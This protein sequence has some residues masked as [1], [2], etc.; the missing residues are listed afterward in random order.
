MS[1]YP[2]PSSH[3][4]ASSPSLPQQDKMPSWDDLSGR[5]D[6]AEDSPNPGKEAVLP[7][8]HASPRSSTAAHQRSPPQMEPP[9]PT[10]PPPAERRL[11]RSLSSNVRGNRA[12]APSALDLSPQGERVLVDQ[13]EPRVRLWYPLRSSTDQQRVSRP[14]PVPPRSTQRTVKDTSPASVAVPLPI[15]GRMSN[16]APTAPNGEAERKASVD[17]YCL[18]AE[19]QTPQV[20]SQSFSPGS[21]LDPSA[22]DRN[23]LI[24][25]GELSTPRWT[26][27]IPASMDNS[28]PPVPS[29]SWSEFQDG[30]GLGVGP[31]K[32]ENEGSI[33]P[34]SE[35][36]DPLLS[37]NSLADFD[38]DSTMTTA[39]AA[40]LTVPDKPVS[41]P[42]TKRDHRISAPV[43]S[44]SWTD[45]SNLSPTSARARIYARRQSRQAQ[46][47]LQDESTVQADHSISTSSQRSPPITSDLP[48]RK[49]S[50]KTPPN[51]APRSKHS[52]N[53]SHDILKHFAP[54]DFSHLPPSPSSASINQ[55][56]RG[57]SST[58]NFSGSNSTGNF[59][60]LAAGV[61]ASPSMTTFAAA[62]T[63]SKNQAPL[64]KSA[65]DAETAEAL[66]KLDG[67]GST[68][69][70][71]TVRNKSSSGVMS[72]SSRPGTPA[73]K[74]KP[75]AVQ[76][77]PKP[78]SNHTSPLDHW[79]DLADEVPAI[80][81]RGRLVHPPDISDKRES[82]SST[83]YVG[84]PN[85]RDSQ[86]W[87]T[88]STTPSSSGK[89]KAARRGSAGSEASVHS[90]IDVAEGT[91]PPVPPLPKSFTVIRQPSAPLESP[92][93][94]SPSSVPSDSGRPRQMSKKWSFS[95]AL[96]L[97]LHKESSPSSSPG[98]PDE[99]K[100]PKTTWSDVNNPPSDEG[101]RSSTTP[102]AGNLSAPLPKPGQPP[103]RSTPSSIPF[104]RR[105]SSSSIPKNTEKASE[106]AT[107]MPPPGSTSRTNSNGNVRKSVLGMSI[108]AMLRG[109]SRR[110][111]S[112]QIYPSTLEPAVE[113][114]PGTTHFASSG[115]N[116]R[117]RGKVSRQAKRSTDDRPCRSR[118][119]PQSRFLYR[120]MLLTL[121]LRESD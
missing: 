109:N 106:S 56:L 39:L 3:K 29:Q 21:P 92:E 113:I 10:L 22:I 85:S 37:L 99:S 33:Q 117:K 32:R 73:G 30:L 1:S 49:D 108:P 87:P 102:V 5:F 97:R 12:P 76:D 98:P 27:R 20:G 42:P 89:D 62:T 111:V 110:N 77:K 65:I 88:T 24:G 75:A 16:S 118:M 47:V 63:P 31:L 121:R 66:R 82:S 115:W 35:K 7:D 6:D 23:N 41:P 67:L 52:P 40:S 112:Q 100:S 46:A 96:N 59:G 116:G 25:V 19:P 51:S 83:S 103:K 95:S 79:V 60:A 34:I 86:S 119:I 9:T 105:T 61:T 57:S 90:E 2:H 80:P 74:S 93:I 81:T 54:K 55:F 4:P 15:V 64:S 45:F 50:R 101:S 58:N 107:S 44:A 13:D 17:S 48:V 26:A 38:F 70:R 53:A 36:V 114:Q 91:V 78:I 18:L 120:Y 104:F 28:A 72:A 43:P 69:V 71:K 84:T 8:V 14:L 68:P 94:S 11:P